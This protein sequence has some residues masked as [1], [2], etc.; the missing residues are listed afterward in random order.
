[1]VA[2]PPD[3]ARVRPAGSPVWLQ[4]RLVPLSTSDAV[5]VI[6]AMASEYTAVASP[7]GLTVGASLTGFMVTVT[8]AGADVSGPVDAV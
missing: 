5:T 7:I 1:M 6:G 2:L 4:V 3:P 8:V